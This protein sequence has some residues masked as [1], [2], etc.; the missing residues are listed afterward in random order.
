MR[1]HKSES[2]IAGTLGQN[3]V[4]LPEVRL[5]HFSAVKNAPLCPMKAESV[6]HEMA[7]EQLLPL[8]I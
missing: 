8:M 4:L 1:L 6:K 3:P 7:N 2:L 5:G